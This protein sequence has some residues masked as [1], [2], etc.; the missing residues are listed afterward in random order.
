MKTANPLE[1]GFTLIEIMVALV[2]MAVLLALGLPAVNGWMTDSRVRSQAEYVLSGLQ[3]ARGEAIKSNTLVRFQLVTPPVPPAVSMGATCALSANSNLWV[4]SRDD[5]SGE[6]DQAAGG[7]AAPVIYL[8]GERERASSVT[9]SI[10]IMSPDLLG[11]PTGVADP[12]L[13]VCFTGT[14]QL[15]R[16]VRQTSG[17]LTAGDCSA[18]RNPALTSP[19]AIQIDITDPTV[20]DGCVSGVLGSVRCMRIQVSPGGDVRMCDPAA[21]DP[22]DPRRCT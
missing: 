18:S 14:G 20:A 17:G 6:C 5:P 2:I 10:G 7:T 22:N 11:L 16:Y 1:R 4:V 19:A 12:E 13:A 21:A 9:T 15:A 8:K 3:L